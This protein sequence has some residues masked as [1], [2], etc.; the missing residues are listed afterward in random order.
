MRTKLLALWSVPI[1][2]I[3]GTSSLA[4]NTAGTSEEAKSLYVEQLNAPDKPINA[5]VTYW[6][7]LTRDYK[8]RHVSNKFPF[9]N[10]DQIRFHIK[11]NFQGFA[12]I[13]MMRGSDGGKAVLF[14]GKG[15]TKNQIAAGREVI[16]PSQEKYLTFD[17][18]PGTETLRLLLSRSPI[19][20][21][22]HLPGEQTVVVAAKSI[23]DSIPDDFAMSS[24]PNEPPKSTVEPQKDSKNLVLSGHVATDITVVRR[25]PNKLLAVDILLNHL[26]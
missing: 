24:G 4:D 1:V 2:T 22:Q 8:T 13:L 11:P 9:R 7:E 25:S 12:Y 26:R 21:Q 16:I 3:F 15:S 20:P 6:I 14:P 18:T 19:N 5:G 17:K 23:G 10:G